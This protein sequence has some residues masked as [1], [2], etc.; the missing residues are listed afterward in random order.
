[1]TGENIMDSMKTNDL[2]S[3][4]NTD[5]SNF[6]YFNVAD[7]VAD[8]IAIPTG[9]EEIILLSWLVVLL[10]TREDSQICFEWTHKDRV[11][12]SAIRSLSMGEV[13]SG[14]LESTLGQTAEAISQYVATSSPGERSISKPA[15]LL[16]S[17]GAL[18]SSPDQVKDNVSGSRS[19]G[20][21]QANRLIA[22]IRIQSTSKYYS[23]TTT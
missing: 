11:D 10:R 15:S 12:E 5:D 13:M 19:T 1:M 2:L 7:L 17:T 16:L 18:S 22:I 3:N 14:G 23:T 8:A 20:P 9:M 6:R 21:D 4:D